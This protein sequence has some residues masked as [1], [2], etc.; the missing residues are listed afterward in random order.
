MLTWRVAVAIGSVIAVAALADYALKPQSV[1][2]FK[3]VAG[4]AEKT[5]VAPPVAASFTEYGSGGTSRLAILLTDEASPWLGLAHGLKSIGVP[6]TIT[7]DYA[8]A[9]RHRVVMVY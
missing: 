8:E 5:V 1:Y 3:G 2:V 7:K 4:P 6:F 9:V